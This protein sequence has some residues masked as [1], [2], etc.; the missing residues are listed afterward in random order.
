MFRCCS[1]CRWLL[2]GSASPCGKQCSFTTGSIGL[3]Y[4]ETPAK[5]NS[6]RS[7]KSGHRVRRG[8]VRAVNMTVIWEIGAQ[9]ETRLV[10]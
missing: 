5:R 2:F 8:S 9:S 1:H 10:C 6:V 7:V 4:G 3:S